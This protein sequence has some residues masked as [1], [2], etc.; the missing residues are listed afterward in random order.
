MSY[1]LLLLPISVLIWIVV[2][3]TALY[4]IPDAV[5]S[6]LKKVGALKPKEVIKEKYYIYDPKNKQWLETSKD[7]SSGEVKS[8]FKYEKVCKDE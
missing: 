5:G 8:V 6:M 7:P 2:V 1:T 3:C 4:F